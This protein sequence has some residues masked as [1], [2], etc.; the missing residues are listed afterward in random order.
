VILMAWSF[1]RFTPAIQG[2]AEGSAAQ[3]VG[4]LCLFGL[5]NKTP[6]HEMDN[7]LRGG[8]GKKYF[9]D[10]C[11]FEFGNIG[12]RN[13]AADQHVVRSRKNREANYVNVFLDG[14][15]GDHFRRLPKSRVYDFHPR[16][17]QGTSNDF[18]APVVT[19]EARLGD[20]NSNFLFGHFLVGRIPVP[21]Q[22]MEG[23]F[24]MDNLSKNE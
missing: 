12:F 13:C 23:Y 3:W 16:I 5:L 9:R 4:L 10:S 14:G 6:P 24:R 7:V 15:R 8:S 20:Q 11:F 19:V 18:C 22:S 17:A 21:V 2:L 1:R